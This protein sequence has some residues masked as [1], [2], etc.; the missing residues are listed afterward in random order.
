MTNKVWIV[1]MLLIAFVIGMM[2]SQNTTAQESNEIGRYQI[3]VAG[4]ERL[5]FVYRLN[6]ETGETRGCAF[7]LNYTLDSGRIDFTDGFCGARP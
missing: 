3:E 1:G 6:T 7:Y 4:L 5:Q 2:F